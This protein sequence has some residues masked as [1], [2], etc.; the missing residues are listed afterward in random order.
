[1][2]AIGRG[3]ERRV[4]LTGASG[5]LGREIACPRRHASGLS[6]TALVRPGTD[7]GHLQRLGIPV[8]R[9][10]L[11]RPAGLGGALRGHPVVLVLTGDAPDQAEMEAGLVGAAVA[12]GASGLVKVSAQSA[13]LQ[14]PVSFGRQ[15][16]RSE[17]AVAASGLP[18]TILRPTF[19][20]QSLLLASAPVA[21]GLLPLPAGRGRIAMVDRRDVAAAVVCALARPLRGDTHTL[22]GPQALHFG[23]VAAAMSTAIG[24]RVRHVDPPL[25]LARL[26]LARGS[27]WW[28][29]GL[30]VELFAALRA[31][32]QSGVT[33]DLARLT[34]TPPRPLVQFLQDHREALRGGRETTMTTM[35]SG[36]ET[37]LTREYGL[38]HPFVGAGMA[39]YSLPPLVAAVSEAGGMGTLGVGFMPPAVLEQA[40]A[41]VA[42]RT[43]R[44]FAVDFITEFATPAH[45][46]VCAATQTPVVVFHWGHPPQTFVDRLHDAGVKVWEQVG[47]TGAAREAA[48]AG[49]DVIIAQGAESGGHVRASAATFSLLPAVVDAV[50][51]VPVLAA[52]GVSQGRHVA[53]ALALGAA[54]VWVGTRLVATPEAAAHEEY[55][56]R[57][58]AADVGDTT[59]TTMFGPEWPDQPVRALRNGVVQE[60]AGRDSEWDEVGARAEP[61]GRTVLG[62]EEVAM[63]KFSV[64]IPT[65]DTD[66]DLDEMCLLAGESVGGIHDVRPAAEVVDEM[67][68]DAAACI[69]RLAELSGAEP[70]GSA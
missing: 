21:R 23:E 6:T 1:M 67:M 5:R 68:R 22:T 38:R 27:G 60:W 44:P 35:T 12:A 17:E 59:V 63:P 28:S 55:K 33:D 26:L 58:V 39:F 46:E 41:D 70:G 18:F 51:P 34:D 29:S 7:A 32:A 56:K 16:R 64:L 52:G 25:P 4:L 66:G 43:P 57:V 47:S 30:V 65:P 62:G 48:A 3:G 8:V 2:A 31:G 40:I 53:A 37:P 54:G 69:G 10:D 9:G 14:P 19:F 15:H 13:G 42:A 11:R 36:I 49:I 61:I 24:R 20:M 50:T 45:I